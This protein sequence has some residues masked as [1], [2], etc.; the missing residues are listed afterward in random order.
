M[1]K[2]NGILFLEIYEFYIFKSILASE[3][4]PVFFI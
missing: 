3:I 2:M 4:M 1:N